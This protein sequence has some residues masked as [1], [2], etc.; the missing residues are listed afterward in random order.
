MAKNK[1]NLL[2]E[3]KETDPLSLFIKK[4]T[5]FMGRYFKHIAF[6][7]GAILFA[8]LSVMLYQYWFSYL[9]QKAEQSLYQYRSTLISEEKSAGG[10]ILDSKP[11]QGFFSAP[12][13]KAE[14]SGQFKL[15]SEKYISS[16]KKFIHTPSGLLA[17]SEMAD[18]LYQYKQKGQAIEM[19]KMAAES[20]KKYLVSSLLRFQLGTYLMDESKYD[21]ALKYF[22]MIQKNEKIKWLWPEILIKMGL[23]YEKQNKMELALKMYNLVKK[24]FPNSAYGKARAS[25]YINLMKAKNPIAKKNK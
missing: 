10:T 15:A 2:I 1:D 17:A 20:N 19:L 24:D 25:K 14:Y 6:V 8:W 11:T 23:I 4:A 3:E 21:L 5:V 9:N 7:L 13:K 12:K 18:F 22:Q 16:I